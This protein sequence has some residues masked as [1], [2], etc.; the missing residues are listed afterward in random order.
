M[1][2]NTNSLSESNNL[3]NN[4]ISSNSHFE[5]NDANAFD[6][7]IS[8][9]VIKYKRI[10]NGLNERVINNFIDKCNTDHIDIN[11]YSKQ[12]RN[13]FPITHTINKV[14]KTIEHYQFTEEV[15]HLLDCL[16]LKKF[17]KFLKFMLTK[18]IANDISCGCFNVIKD[19]EF[20]TESCRKV[21]NLD[22]VT[23]FAHKS[24]Y[25]SYSKFIKIYIKKL[26]YQLIQATSKITSIE[27]FRIKHYITCFNI[28]YQQ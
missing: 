16:V 18:N 23:L 25:L 24:I 13:G 3:S 22:L 12:Q 6:I 7:F 21:T 10:N 8:R 20:R 5:S 17:L 27:M 28:I 1:N 9:N 2:N 15:K 4:N 11:L 19:F 14:I 26:L